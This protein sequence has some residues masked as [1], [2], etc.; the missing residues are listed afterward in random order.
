[1]AHTNDPRRLA[2]ALTSSAGMLCASG[3][4]VAQSSGDDV[5]QE[6]VVTATKQEEP[7]SKVPISVAAFTAEAMDRQGVR[8]IQDIA[9]LT[10]GLAFSRDTFGSGADTSISIRGVRSESGAATTGIYIDDVPIQ[11]R[12]NVQTSFGSSFP[13]VFDLERIEV[14]R[15]PQGTLFGA[16]AQGGAVRFITPTPSLTDSSLYARTEV[17]STEYGDLSYEGGAALGIPL[18]DGVLGLR[19][20]AWYRRDGGFVDRNPAN[21]GAPGGESFHDVNASDT[22]AARVA[23]AYQATEHLRFTPAIFFQRTQVDDS[24]AFW[25]LLSNSDDG[26]FV[27]GYSVRQSASDRFTLPSL[28]VEAGL[29]PVSL[30]SVSSYFD[31]KAEAVQDYTEVNVAFLTRR[32]PPLPFLPGQNAPGVAPA[33][34]KIFSQEVRLSS[35]DPDAR[36]RWTVGAFYSRAKQ[37]ERFAIEDLYLP[38]FFPVELVFGIPLTDGRYVF[39]AQNDSVE[40]QTSLFG[41]GDLK[42]TER[43]SVTAGVRYSDTQF[44]FERTVGGP[45]NYPGTGPDVHVALDGSQSAKPFTPKLGLNFQADEDNL[46]YASIGKGFRVG[47]VNP[48]LFRSPTTGELCTTLPV[49][50]T[51]GPDTTWS[52]EIGSKNRLLGG[53]LRVDASAYLIKWDDIQQFVNPS[54]CAGNGFRDN[55]GQARSR[56]FDLQISA[57]PVRNLLVNLAVGYTNA[58]F[59]KT[60]AIPGTDDDGNAIT[61]IVVRDGDTLGVTPWQAAVSLEQTFTAFSD[62]EA[63]VHLEDRYGSHDNGKSVDRDDSSA[64]S[65]DASQRFDPAINEV[66]L[67]LGWRKSGLDASL[68]VNNLL[69]KAPLLS[70]AHDTSTSTLFYYNTIRPRTIGV[71]LTYRR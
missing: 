51:F 44:D 53:A 56:G 68:F 34:Q 42:L 63:Y 18:L 15:G 70:Q 54:G 65:F 10:P 47:G 6:V 19:A 71:T 16:G 66:N 52:Y 37:N 40:K 4:V 23:L 60:I 49:P 8:S 31:R 21:T 58:E 26:R 38:T 7:L 43:W 32:N 30:T 27:S 35:S 45:L 57:A 62:G 9:S 48:P 12:S 24:G 64:V 29:G 61:Q 2:L 69:D 5:L 3:A 1:M 67:R 41:Q 55:L 59:T 46:F 17:G 22:T 13:Q 14:L 20:S 50:D 36:L 25:G 11:I 39:L 28:K 33:A